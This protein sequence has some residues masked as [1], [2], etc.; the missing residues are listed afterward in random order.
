M[1]WRLISQGQ[2]LKVGVPDVGSN[3]SLLRQKL[4]VLS[5]LPVWVTVLGLGYMVR[6]YSP[7]LPLWMWFS[8]HLPEV[9]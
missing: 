7:L 5:S 6:L 2:V 1:F 8:S 9:Y 3:S 4:W